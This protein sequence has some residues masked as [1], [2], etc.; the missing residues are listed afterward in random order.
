MTPFFL[1]SK[2]AWIFLTP[3][4]MLL[5]MVCAGLLL[6]RRPHRQMFGQRLAAFGA[7][8]LALVS[9]TS[10][11]QSLIDPLERRFP[12]QRSTALSVHGIIVLGGGLGSRATA[13]GYAID[14]SEGA[15]R[16]REA[17][18]LARL[19]PEA[20]VIVSGGRPFPRPGERDEAEALAMVL[21]EFGVA[22]ERMMFERASRTT[23]ENARNVARLVGKRRNDRWLLVTSAFH[24]PRAIGAFRAAGFSAVMAAPTDWRSDRRRGLLSID[25]PGNLARA[26]VATKEY[27]GLLAYRLSGRTATLF[28]APYAARE[29]APAPVDRPKT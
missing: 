23:A 6:A 25:A 19:H 11:S 21:T 7:A 5:C 13:A 2:A 22:R 8:G 29:A 16:V 4:T 26:D 3:S 18:R 28:P 17:A 1:L 12:A 15:D 27:L 10:V 14:L 24:M 9:F 20:T